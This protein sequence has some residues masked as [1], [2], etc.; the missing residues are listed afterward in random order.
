VPLFRAM[1]GCCGLHYKF[2]R[3]PI[4]VDN[5]RRG[6]IAY[7]IRRRTPVKHVRKVFPESARKPDYAQ[8]REKTDEKRTTQVYQ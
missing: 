8:E 5:V 2:H 7:Q 1:H 6:V 4:F 3:E